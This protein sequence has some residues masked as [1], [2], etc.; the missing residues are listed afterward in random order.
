MRDLKL[1]FFLHIELLFKNIPALK[2]QSLVIFQKI[3]DIFERLR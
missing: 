2:S 3:G 1:K